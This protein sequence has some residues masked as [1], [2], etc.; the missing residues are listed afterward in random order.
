MM[1]E[2]RT[3]KLV[4]KQSLLA[5]IV[6]GVIGLQ[7]GQALGQDATPVARTAST[8][9]GQIQ[10]IVVVAQRR[11]ENSQDVP[12][13]V[14]AFTAEMA[15]AEG[16]TDP[17]SLASMVPGLTFNSIVGQSIPFL[18]GVG[19]PISQ[20]GDEPSVAYYVDDVYLP[21]GS[22]SLSNFNSVDR[23]EVEKGPQGTLFGRN[24]TGGVIQVF[25]RDPT[26]D[27]TLEVTAGYANYST[28]STSIYASSAISETLAANVSLYGSKQNDG[29]GEN[30]FTGNPAFTAYDFGGRVKLLFTPAE[31]T[32]LLLTLDHDTTETQQGAAYRGVVGQLAGLGGFPG[33]TTV[34]PSG[35]YNLNQ[36]LDPYVVI[37]QNGVSLKATQDFDWAKIVNITSYRDTVYEV[38][39]D[40]D[41]GPIDLG[42]ALVRTPE[43]TI[44]EELQLVSPDKSPLTWIAGFY[45][46]H[47]N[48]G[49]NPVV[50]SGA[51]YDPA[52]QITGVQYSSS[53]SAFG[54]TTATVLPDTHLT[55]GLRYTIDDRSMDASSYYV[56]AGGTSYVG[57][58]APN[59]PQSQ[60]WNKFTYR[61]SLDHQFTPDIMSYVAYNRGFKSG[62]FNT[63]V[64]PGGEIAPPI[65]PETLDAYSIGA[66][67][68]WL[69]HRLRFNVEGFWYDY[70][71]I[72][73]TE[74]PPGLGGL[75]ILANAAAAT[76]KGIDFDAQA[77]PLPNLTLTA[78]AEVLDGHYDSFA[79]GPFYTYNATT[80][81][82]VTTTA[83]LAGYKT[84][85][86][87]HLSISASVN[88][89]IPMNDRGNLALNIAWSHTSTYY[90]NPDNGQGQLSPSY[91]AQ[92]VLNLVNTSATWTPKSGTWSL[93]LW[94]KNI[95]GQ[96]YWAM[97]E[98]E[99]FATIY[100]PAAPTTYGATATF[101][102]GK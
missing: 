53:Y 60:S 85:Y 33:L 67:T 13:A 1:V 88:Y 40:L 26:R 81:G 17:Q 32:S 18:R 90:S 66:K 49:Y 82:N 59:S 43:R 50:L 44:T 51:F 89:V 58:N 21:S 27:P 41:T 69:D 39:E 16:I 99:G 11:R 37:R 6:T 29:W 78:S 94:G 84:I 46:F 65:A 22:A 102:F 98:E 52:A 9:N 8:D 2:K 73:I 3:N 20:P 5:V 30:L 42:R 75:T 14:T 4:T 38:D 97:A 92:P 63:L 93:Q 91:D 19:T 23:I 83:N 61:A 25:T 28:M 55:L 62:L 34:P 86:S 72:Q 10:E 79:N 54:Q 12:I 45:Y 76:I 80:G 77:K 35:Y 68:E 70:K 64:L 74:V 101:H 24:A 96:K 31:G 100:S 95:T 56:P 87:P 47:D 36:N 48:A 57:A 71:N 7:G 15:R